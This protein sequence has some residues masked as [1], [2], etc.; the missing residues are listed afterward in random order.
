MW[1]RTGVPT[2]RIGYS[3]LIDTFASMTMGAL[4]GRLRGDFGTDAGAR[5]SEL[6]LRLLG[7]PAN[8]AREVS[9][10]E[11]PALTLELAPLPKG[12]AKA[13]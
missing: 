4:S 1:Y 5:V 13:A 9:R 11:I 8:R 3:L 7:V 6:Q 10:R 2:Y 12:L